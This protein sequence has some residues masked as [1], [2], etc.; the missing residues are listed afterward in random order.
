MKTD[1]EFPSAIEVVDA[2]IARLQQKGW[3]QNTIGG[4]NGPNCVSGAL[5]FGMDDLTDGSIERWA[6]WW[7]DG[8]GTVD[9]QVRH[10]LWDAVD[11]TS[12]Y[13]CLSIQA[14]ND[15]P[16]RSAEDVI[17]ALKETRYALEQADA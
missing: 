2:A 14:W 3:T 7:V 15:R 10:A 5:I 9:T 11:R 12:G 6:E 13:R 4:E 8:W 1:P 17:L 16:E